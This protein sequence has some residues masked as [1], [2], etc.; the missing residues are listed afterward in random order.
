MTTRRIRGAVLTTTGAEPPYRDSAP[1]QVRDDIELSEPGEEELLIRVETASVCHSD[2]SVVNGDR[3]RPVPMLL[4][5]ES[6]GIVEQAGPGSEEFAVGQRVVM[7]FLPRCGD[8]AGCASEGVI[9]CINGSRANEEGTLLH[10][11]RRL[12]DTAG[13]EIK[14]HVGVSAFATH[15]VVSKRSVVPV[16]DDVPPEVAAL[17]GCAMLTGGGA[18]LNVAKPQPGD[19]VAVIGMGGV[20]ASALLTVLALD[21]RSVTAID[22][23]EDKLTFARDLGAHAALT[24]DQAEQEGKTFSVVIEAVG[25]PKAFE[26]GYRLLGA[27]GRLVTVGLPRPGSKAEIDPLAMTAGNRAVFGSY[28]GTAVPER[29]IPE[30]EQLW[31]EGR[32]NIEALITSTRPL[33]Q[34]NEAMDRLARAQEVRQ[35][36]TMDAPAGLAAS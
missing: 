6:A 35:I 9:P 12:A 23:H 11:A 13:N 19:D 16:A 26:T 10:G 5:H 36:I 22:T 20:G 25:H 4:G 7:T 14:H 32:L 17:L 27:G 21:V 30:F 28:L 2:L 15:A 1:L 18:V 33:D 34:I 8:C 29:V 31:R 3:P 24:P